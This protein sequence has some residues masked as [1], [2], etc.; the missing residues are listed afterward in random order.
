MNKWKMI[1]FVKAFNFGPDGN[2]G[3]FCQKGLLIKLANLLIN[4]SYRKK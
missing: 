2:F 3:P 1:K 4:A